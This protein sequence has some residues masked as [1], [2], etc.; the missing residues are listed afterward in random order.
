[1]LFNILA[2]DLRFILHVKYVGGLNKPCSVKV[3]EATVANAKDKGK[4]KNNKG[5]PSEV[6]INA[7][8]YCFD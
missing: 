8:L 3:V 5:N 6:A 7:K 1:M 2:E 4:E